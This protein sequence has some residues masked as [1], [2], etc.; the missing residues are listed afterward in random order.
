MDSYQYQTPDSVLS[1]SESKISENPSDFKTYIRILKAK[2]VYKILSFIC[3][4]CKISNK[5]RRIEQLEIKVTRDG[6]SLMF[7]TS[8][9]TTLS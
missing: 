7:K 1:V 6:K 5:F 2:F 4:E 9:F 8:R 3:P